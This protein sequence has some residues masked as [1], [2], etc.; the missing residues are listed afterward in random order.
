[1]LPAIGETI[2]VLDFDGI[3]NWPIYRETRVIWADGTDIHFDHP[4]VDIMGDYCNVMTE[5][6]YQLGWFL[7][8]EQVPKMDILLE[9]I[10][11]S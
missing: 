10:V 1:M 8:N 5:Q 7:S 6:D 9:K 4:V 2:L 11:N 3:N